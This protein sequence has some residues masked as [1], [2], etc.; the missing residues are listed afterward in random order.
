M[1]IDGASSQPHEYVL[2]ALCAVLCAVLDDGAKRSF[3]TR[4]GAR[5]FIKFNFHIPS[6]A[7]ICE[8]E[9]ARVRFFLWY[10]EDC[11]LIGI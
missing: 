9:V 7:V 4:S 8:R 1:S 5:S 2:C 3:R 10:T 6:S 11:F